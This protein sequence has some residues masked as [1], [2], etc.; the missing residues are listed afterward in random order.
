M[1]SLYQNT[2]SDL[3]AL[4]NLKFEN[5]PQLLWQAM[6]QSEGANKRLALVG[7]AAASLNLWAQWF[8]TSQSRGISSQCFLKII[9]LTEYRRWRHQKTKVPQE[10]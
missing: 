9:I 3:K 1:S 10:R 2:I 5:D 6:Q 4:F 7:D 8:P